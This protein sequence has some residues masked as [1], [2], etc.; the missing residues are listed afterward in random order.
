MNFLPYST[1]AFS[2]I[3]KKASILLC[4]LLIALSATAQ[5][6]LL[7][8][9]ISV[10]LN[11]VSV[12]Q[13]LEALETHSG[14][15]FVYSADLLDV[16]R[17][18]SVHLDHVTLEDALQQ[19]FPNGIGQLAV[20]GNRINLQ[21]SAGKGTI[22]G[23]VRT[24]DGRPAGY[25]TVSL[26]SNKMQADENGRFQFRQIEVGTY[27][28]T[29]DYVG[30]KRQAKEVQVQANHTNDI[31]ITLY[32]D[33]QALQEV[34]VNGERVN[35]FA[36]KETDYVARMPLSNLENPQVYSVVTKQLM[37]E[38]VSYTIADAIR[39]AAGAVP[40]TNPSGGLSAY[41]R[42]FGV[43][44]NARNGMEST[45]E[46]S[47]MDLA[48]IERIE[49]L[50]GPSGTLFGSSVSSFGGVVNLVTKKPIEAK[51]TE[52]SYTTGSFGLNRV[53][54]DFNTPL[55]AEKKVLFRINS[56][57]HRERS[58]LSYGFNNTFLVAPS[59][60]YRVNERLSLNVDAELLHVHNT[61]PMNFLI[62]SAD[63][64]QPSDILLDYR[65]TLYHDNVDVKNRAT[66]IYA[67]AVYKLSDNF[68]ST[69]LFSY[70]SEDVERSYQRPV[71]WMSPRTAVRASAVY[72]PVYN[73]YT[74]LQHNINGT[75]ATGSI[76][77]KLLL[78]AN[79][80]HYASN[81]L[82]AEAQVIDQ[83]DVTQPFQPVLRQSIDELVS[84]APFPSPTQN[85]ISVYASDMIELLPRL[86]AM[87]SLRMDRFDREATEGSD[88]GFEQTSF[89]P[90]FGLVYQLIP[91]QLSLF[92]N[93]M[94]GF[95]NVAPALQPDGSRQVLDPLFANQA[96]GGVKTELFNKKFSFTA[97]YYY[98]KIDN[99]TRTNA[100]L[101][102]VQDGEQVSKGIDLELI[103][104]PLTGLNIVAGYAYNNNRIISASDPA[105][106]GNKAA[107]APE[108][109]AN[110]WA[111]YTF[112]KRLKGLGVGVGLNYVDKMYRATDNTFFIPSYSLA[113]A[114]IYYQKQAW[115]IQL[116]ANNLFDKRYWDYWGNPQAPANFAAN[117]N[118][119]F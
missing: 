48:N 113:N 15:T 65:K 54:I 14:C 10:H 86:S 31:S 22:R 80:R 40:V 6:S 105:I 94:S 1:K 26:G 38:Q 112:Q 4:I 32:E 52:L 72:G 53:T 102:I 92:G 51:R 103:A 47:A 23:E 83:I 111:S 9:R 41:F 73:G 25:V 66:R 61:Q 60:S 2:V 116:K 58:F 55:D 77:H 20:N 75:F 35:R 17:Q 39:N 11:N 82:F 108:N 93:Y 109:V 68:K 70:V 33:A 115:G 104:Q 99:A 37:Q 7:K 57:L 63:I 114:V 29:A 71:I 27:Q 117:L 28:L 96:E 79:Y 34:V 12:S 36:N 106:E 19:L 74:N 95:Q 91:Q 59:L 78:G 21:P 44:I 84:Y 118:F 49:V 8:K 42:G 13:I 100:A 64:Q 97:S 81:F 85:T 43:G 18:T 76:R 101:F 56:A 62:R 5:T 45:S 89:A 67:E 3:W 24:N 88:D 69:T 119:R 110:I 16:A 50:K 46:R 87:L 107:N 98:I 30:V 90:K